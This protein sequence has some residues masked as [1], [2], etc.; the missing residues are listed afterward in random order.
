MLFRS[1]RWH[2]QE[3]NIIFPKSTNPHHIKDNFDIFDFDLTDDEMAEIR[4]VDKGVRF[5]NM[6][7]KQQEAQFTSWELDD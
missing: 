3:G 6:T 5:F 4:K 7:L 2:I 1:L